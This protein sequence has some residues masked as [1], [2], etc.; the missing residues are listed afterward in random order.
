MNIELST[1]PQTMRQFTH[2]STVIC[3]IWS[4]SRMVQSWQSSTTKLCPPMDPGSRKNTPPRS[5]L[6]MKS[7]GSGRAFLSHE[8]L[9]CWMLALPTF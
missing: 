3:A 9:P 2:S 5:P 4:S 7:F 8:K 6:A 1:G